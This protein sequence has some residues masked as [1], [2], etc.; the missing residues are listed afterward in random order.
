LRGNFFTLDLER[1]R[2]AFEK[3]PWVRQANL[4][5]AWPDRLEVLVEEHVAVAR[6]RDTGLVNTYGEVF[7]AASNERLPLFAG[8][9]GAAAEMVEHYRGFREL[10]LT[11][12]REPVELRLSDRRA[13]A[14]RSSDGYFLELGRQDMNAR[15]AR[16]VAGYEKAVAQLQPGAYRVDLRYP[17]GFAVRLPGLRWTA[18]ATSQQRR[19]APT[20]RASDDR[21]K[22]A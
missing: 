13:W 22:Q 1:T 8:P 20:D 10:L 18:G 21:P 9:E 3:L 6:W 4:R 7:E 15:L 19:D 16:F 12:G 14:L 17:N 11:V 2:L 5:R